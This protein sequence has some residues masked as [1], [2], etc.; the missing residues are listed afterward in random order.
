MS[1][2]REITNEDIHNYGEKRRAQR[3]LEQIKLIMNAHL[4]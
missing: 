4:K 3:T 2:F 1:Y